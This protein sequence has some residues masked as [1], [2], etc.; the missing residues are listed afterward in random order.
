MF[1]IIPNL[2]INHVL[3]AYVFVISLANCSIPSANGKCS[4]L[5]NAVFLP[6]KIHPQAEIQNIEPH[7]ISQVATFRSCFGIF[8]NISFSKLVMS[9]FGII[10]FTKHVCLQWPIKFSCGINQLKIVS[11]AHHITAIK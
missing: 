7:F 2:E 1:R 3:L 11:L 5:K 10:F 8:Y 6:P 9:F 4:F